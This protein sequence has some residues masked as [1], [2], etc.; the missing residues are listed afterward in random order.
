MDGYNCTEDE[1]GVERMSEE[2]EE[3][4]MYGDGPNL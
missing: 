1:N 3:D 4:L 2:D